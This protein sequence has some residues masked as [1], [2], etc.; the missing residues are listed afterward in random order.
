MTGRGNP[1]AIEAATSA[2][3]EGAVVLLDTDSL[4]GLH[5]LARLER[6]VNALRE[7]K[8]ST[9]KRPFLLL[10]SS[11]DEVVRYGLPRRSRDL[12][13]LRRIWPGPLT[14][15]LTPQPETPDWWCDGG[16]GLAAR[17]PASRPLRELIAAL[18][19]PL[20]STS[21]NREGEGPART[22][23]EAAARFPGLPAFEL[24][25]PSRG[26]PSTLVDLRG[27]KAVVL[28]TGAFGWPEDDTPA[29]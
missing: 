14:A 26:T 29:P 27:P 21:A 11:V 28:R 17:V 15:L 23:H 12:R 16:R 3:R 4:P 7:V 20:F 25:M 10:F 19:A 24:G 22:L 9:T 8:Q 18:K 5:A 6:S 13:T 1:A 2:L